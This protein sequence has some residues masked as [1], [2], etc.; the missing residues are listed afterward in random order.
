MVDL[1]YGDG[2]GAEMFSQLMYDYFWIV[3]VIIA[4]HFLKLTLS[5]KK[6]GSVEWIHIVVSAMN[7]TSVAIHFWKLI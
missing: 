4:V 6:F 5:S 1:G 2:I 7:A 3:N